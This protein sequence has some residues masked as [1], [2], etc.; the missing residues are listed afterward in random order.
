MKNE[1]VHFIDGEFE[2]DVNVN[3]KTVWLTQAQICELFERDQLVVSR[4]INKLFVE[5]ELENKSNMQKSHI[6]NSDKQVAF[7]SSLR[8]LSIF[9]D[10]F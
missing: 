8:L 7:Y 5:N 10:K 9:F 2:L 1:L 3:S 6:P 4:H